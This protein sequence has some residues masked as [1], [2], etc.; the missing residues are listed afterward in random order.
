MNH[1]YTQRSESNVP[2]AERK[3]EK[4]WLVFDERKSFI[5]RKKYMNMLCVRTMVLRRLILIIVI[6]LKESC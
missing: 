4:N 3:K 6:Q 1:L 5:N 2:S